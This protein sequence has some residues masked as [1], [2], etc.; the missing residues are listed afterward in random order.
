MWGEG[1]VRVE[2]P[3]WLLGPIRSSLVWRSSARAWI[4]QLCRL[5]QVFWR[6]TQQVFQ[7]ANVLRMLSSCRPLGEGTCGGLRLAGYCLAPLWY[8]IQGG[9]FSTKAKS[10]LDAALS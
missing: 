2:G 5:I 4:G 10:T 1:L 9:R 7:A 6:S 8:R 3:A